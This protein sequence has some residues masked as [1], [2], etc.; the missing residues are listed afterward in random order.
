MSGRLNHPA[1][2]FSDTA[3]HISFFFDQTSLYIL[4]MTLS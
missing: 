3:T 2:T 4:F 1:A